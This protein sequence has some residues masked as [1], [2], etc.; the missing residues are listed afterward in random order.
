M[1]SADGYCPASPITPPEERDVPPSGVVLLIIPG[2]ISSDTVQVPQ[3]QKYEA[4][5]LGQPLGKGSICEP[6]ARAWAT[7]LGDRVDLSQDVLACPTESCLQG[8]DCQ[9]Y[10]F[11]DVGVAPCK[12]KTDQ[13]P[14]GTLY[15]VELIVVIPIDGSQQQ[16]TA[17]EQ[18]GPLDL[19]LVAVTP[20]SVRRAVMRARR[21]VVVSAPCKPGLNYCD[22]YCVEVSVIGCSQWND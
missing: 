14:V 8:G 16:T 11:R 1:P 4:C 3:G 10:L 20:R 9:G 19:D 21:Y 18:L 5:P 7:R 17:D 13:G 6:G 2:S 22:G 15:T 12:V